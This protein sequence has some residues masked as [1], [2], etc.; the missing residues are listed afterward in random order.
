MESFESPARRGFFMLLAE[1]IMRY[2]SLA[3][4]IRKTLWFIIFTVAYYLPFALDDL[5][6]AVEDARVRLLLAEA[7]ANSNIQ[8]DLARNLLGQL[9][10]LAAFYALLD[11]TAR[12]LARHYRIDSLVAR[13][14]VLVAGWILLVAAN[15]TLF[16]L[17]SY[18]APLSAI[19]NP[20]AVIVAALLLAAGIV[21][22]C[23][24][25]MGQTAGLRR[26]ILVVGLTAPLLILTA[27]RDPHAVPA[28][29]SERAIVIIGIDSLSASAF[30][31][32]RPLFPHLSALLD[33]AVR[34]EHAY[35]PLARTFPAWMSILSGQPPIEHGAIFNLRNITHVQRNELL[36]HDLRQKG[37]RTVFAIDERRFCNIDASFGFDQVVGPKAGALDFVLQEFNDTPLTNLAL[38]TRLGAWLFPYSWINVASHANYDAERFV[39]ESISAIDNAR[40]RFLA[41]HF[42]SAHFP[43]KS[44]HARG[45]VQS[46][47]SFER[48]YL[49]A[50]TG[51]D[52][53][54]GRLVDGLRDNGTLDNALV[55]LLSDHGE[56]LGELEFATTQGGQPLSIKSYGHGVQI[57][58][59]IQH[60]V[61]FGLIPFEAGLPTYAVAE[62]RDELVSLM[63]IREII[64][65][66][67][68]NGRV[69]LPNQRSCI[70]V[71][72]GIRFAAAADYR[73][74]SESELAAQ[75]ASFYE[76][77]INGRLQIREDRLGALI[78]LKDVGLR[79]QDRLTYFNTNAQAYYAYRLDHERGLIE[80]TPPLRD[81]QDIED[82]RARL[83]ALPDQ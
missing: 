17:S 40:R 10:L 77:G 69:E 4:V 5:G 51:V 75:S 61:V 72:T 16:Q 47:N 19:A 66:Y 33:H 11:W 6:L 9:L 54:V 32:N 1:Q 13:L 42:E 63:D 25:Q 7:L 70:P 41:I 35:T 71:E 76:I 56:A 81:M 23:G 15:A 68:K 57:L 22:A 78:E 55:I 48:R 38:Q 26:A 62:R 49:E 52:A 73:S 24:I 34:F 12:I 65:N 67:A 43:F 37:Y 3:Q 21:T 27:G 53:Q 44:R 30:D 80:I 39:D 36:T 14:A 8:L 28:A 46:E 20:P 2:K 50:L 31:A 82:L 59:D 74:M 60:R 58:S 18:S 29:S 83:R 45:K 79:C 64:Q